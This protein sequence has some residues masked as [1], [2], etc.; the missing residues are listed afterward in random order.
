MS[1]EKV[2]HAMLGLYEDR[3]IMLSCLRFGYATWRTYGVSYATFRCRKIGLIVLSFQNDVHPMLV[4]EEEG[5]AIWS[6]DALEYPM[7]SWMY[8]WSE[9]WSLGRLAYFSMH[10]R[11]G[12]WLLLSQGI[13]Y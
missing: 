4:L 7:L 12:V 8:D 10:M 11:G 1:I 9:D 2:G 6:S 13:H 3:H 5:L